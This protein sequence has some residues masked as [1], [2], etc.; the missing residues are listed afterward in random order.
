MVSESLQLKTYI[1]TIKDNEKSVAAAERCANS[2]KQFNP[3]FHGAFT[4]A[5]DPVGEL[6]KLGIP[7]HGFKKGERYSVL[8]P[9]IS[10]FLS[11]RSLWVKSVEMNE[12][13]QILEHDAVATGYVPHVIKYDKCISLGKPS[14][15][16]F[17]NPSFIGNGPLV[18]KPY[19]TGAHAYRLKP[20]GAK[21]LL[22]AAKKYACTTDVMLDIRRFA[23]LEEYYPWPFEAK[24]SFTTLQKLEGCK[25]KHNFGSKYEILS[26]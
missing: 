13:M 9:T 7:I 5:D 24:D 14:Y 1:I 2:I 23:F 11:H 4:P 20:A 3:I 17:N 22:E 6:E 25:A 19:F 8:E 12:E 15:G 10:A 26:S 18:S 21:I 16:K